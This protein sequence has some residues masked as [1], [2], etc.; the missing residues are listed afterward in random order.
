MFTDICEG[1]KY[2]LEAQSK[3]RIADNTRRMELERARADADLLRMDKSRITPLRDA[4]IA[5]LSKGHRCFLYDSLHIPVDSLIH[6]KKVAPVFDLNA[7]RAAGMDGWEVIGVVP[8]TSGEV[9]QN[10]S[11]GATMGNT[12][13]AAMG[14][15][16]IGVHIL[17]RKEVFLSD[18]DADGSD[19]LA[20]YL[21]K[22]FGS[23]VSG[24][25]S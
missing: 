25:I 10:I 6:G 14:G 9:L 22:H 13:G 18:L 24:T 7:V 15:N 20:A 1:C 19:H 16:V 5:K 2:Q 8:Q 17:L 4:A 12:W 21:M 3:Q 23:S 11:I